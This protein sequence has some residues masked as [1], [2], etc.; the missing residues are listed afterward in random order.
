M[1]YNADATLEPQANIVWISFFT[2]NLL[3]WFYSYPMLYY[4][5]ESH[6]TQLILNKYKLFSI[7]FPNIKQIS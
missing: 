3:H 4:V 7:A 2:V 6:S 1:T 5:E